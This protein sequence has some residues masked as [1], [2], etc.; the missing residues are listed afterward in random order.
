MMSSLLRRF[1][2][3][4]VIAS[5]TVVA[6]A[7]AQTH[8]VRLLDVPT[9]KIH[10][11]VN[12]VLSARGSAD[13]LLV[14]REQA[15]LTAA[16]ALPSKEE[17]GRYVFDALRSV[18]DRTQRPIIDRL[19]ARGA[20]H[21]T[22]HI[23]NIIRAIVDSELAAEL[24]ARPDI[25]LID[26][27]PTVSGVSQAARAPALTKSTTNA[28]VRQLSRFGG[29]GRMAAAA[30]AIEP[31]LNA[32]GAPTVWALGF[33]G[34]GVVVAG[35]DTGY[36]WNHPAIMTQ[37]RGWSPTGVDHNYNWHDA[38][39]TGGGTCGVNAV[40]PCDD[41]YHGTHTMGTVCGDDGAG[42]QIGM[43]PG[44]KWIGARN[45]DQG[46]GTP[47]TYLECFEWLLAP[48]PVGGTPAQGDPSRAPHV[49]NNSWG[50]PPSEGCTLTSLHLAMQAHR[51]AGIVSVVS[52]GNYG[53]G[54]STVTDPPAIYDEAYSVGSWRQST[55]ALSNFS[56]R[57]PV[58]IDGSNRLKPDLVAPGQTIRS[59]TP[60]NSYANLSGTSMAGPHVCGAVALLMSAHPALKGQ[61]AIVETV[62][63]DTAIRY[64]SASCSSNGT[65]PNNVFGWGRLDVAAAVAAVRGV[66]VSTAPLTAS[67]GSS[68]TLSISITNIGYLSD[69][70]TVSVG[71][72]TWPATVVPGTSPTGSIA[73]GASGAVDITVTIPSTVQAGAAGSITVTVTSTNFASETATAVIPLT[74]TALVPNFSM[75][76][77]S[78]GAPVVLLAANL[79]PSDTYHCLF[80]LEPNPTGVGNG[81]Y[82]GLWTSN[83]STLIDQFVLPLGFVPF[84]F[85]AT[86]STEPLGAYV[87]PPG[88]VIEAICF[89]YT[90]GSLLGVSPV[91]A[92]VTQ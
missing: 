57:G 1:A 85:A 56:S 76:Q 16:T 5:A 7:G 74:T 60:T 34:Q 17:K 43:A 38:I 89:D 70:F 52:A 44:A 3:R 77:A 64:N 73:A 82:L 8:D 22:F 12:E 67:V 91:A 79:I 72:T 20:V 14:L 47:A 68:T 9:N 48:Y 27:N 92:L 75:T 63:N 13:V 69:T 81:P 80:S 28:L 33:T 21:R 37:Y 55:N 65:Y 6:V 58:T 88:L 61:V 49:T 25:A 29:I 41:G 11:S 18:A 30:L 23:G 59:C 4:L 35:Q 31:G 26:P 45:M 83:I 51:A 46:N 10:Q 42:N 2:A 71:S 62:L 54:C 90:N 84:H 39:H 40:A 19:R 15:D 53:S 32:S 78:A 24:A 50:C 86:Q 87:L 66:S 36:Q